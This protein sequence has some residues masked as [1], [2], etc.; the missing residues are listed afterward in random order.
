MRE[1]VPKWIYED[2]LL[3]DP[4]NR[5]T[6]ECADPHTGARPVSGRAMLWIAL[7]LAELHKLL[8]RP[9]AKARRPV[10][11]EY[12]KNGL[13]V[14]DQLC[15]LQSVWTKPWAPQH[16]ERGLCARGNV[17]ARYDA[18]LTAEFARCAMLYGSLTGERDYFERG[19]AAL[20]AV[21]REPGLSAITQARVA[22][23]TAAIESEYGSI[24]VHVGGRWAVPLNGWRIARVEFARG[25]V[26]IRIEPG[27]GTGP[28]KV[29]FG[30]M[31]AGAHKVRLNGELARYSREEMES[32]IPVDGAP[33]EANEPAQLR[34]IPY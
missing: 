28:G 10:P 12:L 17:G 3:L 9:E 11:L 26:E 24:Y 19:A 21:T 25:S 30:G 32:G 13:A 6:L 1:I 20:G 34:L 7:L 8:S 16:L 31:R 33:R 18:E 5:L 29:V 4:V 2:H 15:L 14:F 27:S 23:C 22:A